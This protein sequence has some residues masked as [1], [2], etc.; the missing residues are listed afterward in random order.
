MR[1]TSLF[2]FLLLLFGAGGTSA[3]QSGNPYPRRVEVFTTAERP[4][5]GDPLAASAGIELQVY[6]LDGIQQ[7]EAKL[8]RNLPADPNQA[9]EIALQ[10]LQPWDEATTARPSKTIAG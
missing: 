9:R 6:E 1:S 7:F 5:A 2:L 10:R 4:V 8:S 3:A